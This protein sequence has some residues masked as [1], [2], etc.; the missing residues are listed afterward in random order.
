MWTKEELIEL[1]F[2]IEYVAEEKSGSDSFEY[3]AIDIG[4]VSLLASDINE[5]NSIDSIFL[6]NTDNIK[7]S[8]EFVKAFS[9]EAKRIDSLS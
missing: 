3:A 7:L 6:F 9:K 2:T 4:W 1:G 5:D 8:K